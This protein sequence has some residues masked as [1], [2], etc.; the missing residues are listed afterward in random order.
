MWAITLCW[1][2]ASARADWWSRRTTRQHSPPPLNGLPANRRCKPRFAVELWRDSP[3]ATAST[4]WSPVT[5]HCTPIFI[6]QPCAT[7]ADPD[8]LYGALPG[9]NGPVIIWLTLFVALSILA[10][11]RPAYAVGLYMLSF[12]ACP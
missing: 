1:Q 12:F 7:A 11:V 3:N 8:E 2:E 5:N 9:M 6:I 4:A 10:L